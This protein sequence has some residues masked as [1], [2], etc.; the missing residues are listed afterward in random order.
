[1]SHG[2][3]NCHEPPRIIIL[4]Q[5]DIPSY[6][7]IIIVK[8]DRDCIDDDDDDDDDDDGDDDDDDD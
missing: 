7:P 3:V 8:H 5:N 1:M 2:S 6:K 4:L